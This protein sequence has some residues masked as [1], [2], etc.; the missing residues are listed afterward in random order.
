MDVDRVVPPFVGVSLLLGFLFVHS[1]QKSRL[2]KLA[3]QPLWIANLVLVA[4][5]SAYV[6]SQPRTS[7]VDAELQLATREGLVALLLVLISQAGFTI[8]PFWAVLVFGYY[9]DQA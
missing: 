7:K 1:Q 5:F 4:V 6:F 2:I 8:I 9:V 3:Q